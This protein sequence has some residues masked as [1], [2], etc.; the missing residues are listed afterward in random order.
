MD[1][2]LIAIFSLG[3]TVGYTA[4]RP[5]SPST[6]SV[7]AAREP[8]SSPPPR[9]IVVAPPR[10]LVDPT[11]EPA[12]LPSDA[13][14]AATRDA[15]PYEPRGVLEGKVT[16]PPGEPSYGVTITAESLV[17]GPHSTRTDNDGNYR[18]EGLPSAMYKVHFVRYYDGASTDREVGV[19]QL[20]PTELDATFDRGE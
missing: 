10:V 15:D 13:S 4:H 5:P 1:I 20:D 16:E 12:S 17:D 11:A 7:A 19:N 18:L 8:V 3:A 14:E 6:A 9:V 2:R